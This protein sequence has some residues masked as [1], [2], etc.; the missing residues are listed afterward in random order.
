MNTAPQKPF[1]IITGASGNLGRSVADAL[2]R[3]YQPVGLDLH[4]E[5]GRFTVLA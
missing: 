1:V 2:A 4:G 5:E 3:S